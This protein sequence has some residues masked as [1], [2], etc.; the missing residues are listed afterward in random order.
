MKVFSRQ[1]A[2]EL[3]TFGSQPGTESAICTAVD[4]VLRAPLSRR[5]PR[6]ARTSMLRCR[7][8]ESSLTSNSSSQLGRCRW[9]STSRLSEAAG[10]LSREV[11]DSPLCPWGMAAWRCVEQPAWRSSVCARGKMR[12]L[13]AMDC[14]TAALL[15]AGPPATA[16]DM[17]WSAR[18]PCV[19]SLVAPPNR[20]FGA[21]PARWGDRVRS[22]ARSLRGDMVSLS[23]DSRCGTHCKLSPARRSV[24]QPWL[25]RGPGMPAARI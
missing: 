16:P 20:C 4:R 22:P 7:D 5:G 25:L 11:S 21:Q 17:C 24:S 23:A 2:C 6:Q 1:I 18:W 19:R 3:P 8:W 9:G 10:R 13:G 15:R 14:P 12:N